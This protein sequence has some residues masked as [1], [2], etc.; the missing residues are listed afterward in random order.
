MAFL[1]GGKCASAYSMHALERAREMYGP[2]GELFFFIKKKLK[3][4]LNE[5]LSNPSVSSETL[6][7]CALIGLHLLAAA[8]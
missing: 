2:R 4:A 3:V 7:A 1:P 6:M 5:V 8:L